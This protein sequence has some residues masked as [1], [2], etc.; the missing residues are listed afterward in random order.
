MTHL[1]VKERPGEEERETAAVLA[2]YGLTAEEVAPLVAAL[3]RRPNAWVDF[4]MRFEETGLEHGLI[5]GARCGSAS[6]HCRCVH[7]RWNDP[8]LAPYFFVPSPRAACRSPWR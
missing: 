1:E 6:Y 2:E 5:H 8:A 4:M 3:K 7:R